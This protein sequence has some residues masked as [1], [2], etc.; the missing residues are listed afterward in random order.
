MRSASKFLL[1]I[2][3]MTQLLRWHSVHCNF[4][5]SYPVLAVARG[6]IPGYMDEW[7]D[8]VWENPAWCSTFQGAVPFLPGARTVEPTEGR[9]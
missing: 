9:D 6:G 5:E 1:P 2:Y 3:G 4:P 7:S 8:S